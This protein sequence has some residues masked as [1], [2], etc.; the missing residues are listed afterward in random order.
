MK[1]MRLPPLSVSPLVEEEID[2]PFYRQRSWWTMVG[3]IIS[4]TGTLFGVL[5]GKNPAET[6]V[7]IWLASVCGLL[8]LYFV[9]AAAVTATKRAVMA[10]RRAENTRPV[11]NIT[12][13]RKES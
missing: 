4:V 7:F 12:G 13:A 6:A 10:L 2:Q 5:Y 1:R 8:Q 11:G 9:R 3:G